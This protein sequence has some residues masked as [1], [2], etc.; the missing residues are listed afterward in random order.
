MDGG[1]RGLERCW[2]KRRDTVS[3]VFHRA[4]PRGYRGRAGDLA[5]SEGTMGNIID[6]ERMHG[7]VCGQPGEVA[8]RYSTGTTRH[9][10]LDIYHPATSETHMVK[11][12]YDVPSHRYVMEWR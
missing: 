9:Y 4:S 11:L 5:V 7:C 6:L 8:K 2:V 12:H 10:G 3:V 1:K